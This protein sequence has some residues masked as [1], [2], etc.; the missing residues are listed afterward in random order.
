[1]AFGTAPAVAETKDYNHIVNLAGMQRMLTQKMSKESLLVALG[2]D[3]EDNLQQL[4]ESRT[5]FDRMLKG[6]RHGD[7]LLGLPET[8]E[9]EVLDRL[10]KVEELWPLLQ[11]AIRT[12]LARG[13]VSAQEVETI[14]ELNLPLLSAMEETVSAYGRVAKKGALVSVLTVAINLS[15]RQRMLTQKMCKEV[16]L[17]AYGFDERANRRSLAD[18]IALFDQTLQGLIYGNNDLGL[19]PAPTAEIK[20]QLR[21]VQ[22]LW[23]A[24]RPLLEPVAKGGIPGTDTV[25]QVARQN[26]PLL[27]E[28]N[29][30]V[31]MYEHL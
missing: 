24:F 31:V 5:L 16:F 1:M 17:I 22:G 2:I 27:E 9:P 20:R 21:K 13:K 23:D 3:R 7:A 8:T 11:S 18:S 29:K 14:A 10:S 12:S 26:L 4:A 30:A 19:L 25:A 28:M 15:G 6:L